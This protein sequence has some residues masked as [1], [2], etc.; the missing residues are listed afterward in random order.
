MP[1]VAQVLLV[2]LER[3][4]SS[5]F[6]EEQGNTE[7]SSSDD[8]SAVVYL[9]AVPHSDPKP[10]LLQQMVVGL[11]LAPTDS[12]A[13]PDQPSPSSLLCMAPK[14]TYPLEVDTQDQLDQLGSDDGCADALAGDP[15]TA[16]KLSAGKA[17]ACTQTQSGPAVKLES[18]MSPACRKR[19]VCRSVGE[20]A[21]LRL[22][23]LLVSKTTCDDEHNH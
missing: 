16:A 18:C 23:I 8:V 20:A 21:V 22:S 6:G 17:S 1:P 2:K 3:L 12:A 5:L 15:S 4:P 11:R 7:S 13:E 19:A 14:C 10:G 9:S